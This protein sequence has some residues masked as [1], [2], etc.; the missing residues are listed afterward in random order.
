MVF[1][2]AKIRK[3]NKHICNLYRFIFRSV[4]L[5]WTIFHKSI[6][7]NVA[8]LGIM[9]WKAG[10]GIPWTSNA[11]ISIDLW[12]THLYASDWHRLSG[13]KIMYIAPMI[14]ENMSPDLYVP[15]NL[16]REFFLF[17]LPNRFAGNLFPIFWVGQLRSVISVR[18]FS[19]VWSSLPFSAIVWFFFL[20]DSWKLLAIY[21]THFW[22]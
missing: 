9:L 20:F 1:Y 5:D 8:C 19:I 16:L 15:L 17:C 7:V 22:G 2:I 13:W 4:E 14:Y 11:I 3:F 6:P 12:V 10:R 18:C 21:S